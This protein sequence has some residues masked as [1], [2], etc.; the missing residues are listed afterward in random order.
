MTTQGGSHRETGSARRGPAGVNGSGARWRRQ[1]AL[2]VLGLE[3]RLLLSNTLMIPVTS[4]A[5]S[6]PD[7]LRAAIATANAATMPV[8]IEF[9]L[10]GQGRRR[11]R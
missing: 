4:T 6:G 9:D 7:T 2:S 11:S 10:P 1:V 3:D 5:D 8:E